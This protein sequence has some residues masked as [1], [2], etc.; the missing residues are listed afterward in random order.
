[1]SPM[2]QVDG[3]EPP[4][5]LIHGT[6]DTSIPSWMSE[7]FATALEEA[8]ADVELLLLE[9]E[10]HA[11]LIQPLSSPANVQSLEAIEAFLASLPEQ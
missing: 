9:E 7:D 2:S 5:L 8:G 6:S 4:F 3:S 10:R 11:F 1:M